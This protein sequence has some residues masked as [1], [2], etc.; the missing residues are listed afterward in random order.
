MVWTW[1]SLTRS[2][3][4]LLGTWKAAISLRNRAVVDEQLYGIV[5]D[6]QLL[7]YKLRYESAFAEGLFE[8]IARVFG[9]GM[10]IRTAEQFKIIHDLS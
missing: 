1:V 9:N 5:S 8:G 10:E 3:D 7:D 4:E 6:A 2:K